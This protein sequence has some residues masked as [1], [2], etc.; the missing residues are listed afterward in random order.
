VRS[1]TLRR[2]LRSIAPAIAV[3]TGAIVSAVSSTGI[4]AM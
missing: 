1:E 2:T 3:A 4:P